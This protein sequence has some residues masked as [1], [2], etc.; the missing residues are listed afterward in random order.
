MSSIIATH[1]MKALEHTT[2]TNEWGEETSQWVE[3]YNNIKCHLSQNM[4][5]T[6]GVTSPYATEDKKFKIFYPIEFTIPVGS[7]LELSPLFQGGEE[8]TFLAE[9]SIAYQFTKKKEMKVSA[10]QE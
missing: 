6:V 8:Y 9:P 2:V 5:G 3:K 7:R 1:S 10:W 4:S